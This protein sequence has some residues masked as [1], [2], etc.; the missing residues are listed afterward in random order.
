M[1]VTNPKD[2]IEP[3]NVEEVIKAFEQQ[4]LEEEKGKKYYHLI[5]DEEYSRNLCDEIERIYTEAGW[6]KV[7]C[8]TS[9]ESGERPGLTGLQL[10]R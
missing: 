6:S 2:M 1:K 8:K 9:S 3:I 4:F 5:V 7:V 10:Y